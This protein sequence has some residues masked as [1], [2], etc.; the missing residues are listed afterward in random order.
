MC[1]VVPLLVLVVGL[2][3]TDAPWLMRL[4]LGSVYLALL[5]L[6]YFWPWGYALLGLF[7][8]CCYFLFF[9]TGGGKRWR[10]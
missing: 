10:L 7:A 4:V 1:T 5:A 9:G 2:W 6:A 3:A 8:A